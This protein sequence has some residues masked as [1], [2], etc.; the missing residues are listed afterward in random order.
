MQLNPN[1]TVAVEGDGPFAKDWFRHKRAL[2]ARA[3]LSCAIRTYYFTVRI[4]AVG[5]V[6]TSL[7]GV[8]SYD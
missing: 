5:V 3:S 6:Y 4:E 8:K 2:A 1:T 7:L